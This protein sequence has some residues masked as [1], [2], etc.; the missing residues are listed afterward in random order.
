MATRTT[1]NGSSTGVPW[2]NTPERPEGFGDNQARHF[3][4]LYDAS[5]LPLTGV[6]GS[7]DTVTATV[8]P[9]IGSGGLVDGMKFTITWA[10]NNTGPT[11]LAIGTLPPVPVLNGLGGT[12]IADTLLAGSRTMLEYVSG[13]FRILTS[14]TGNS[15][16]TDFFQRITVSGVW[17]KPPGYS[18]DA[19][20]T[21][22]A[23]G[24]GGGGG[25]DSVVP[26]GNGGGGGGYVEGQI[27]YSDLPST[28]TVT[29]GAGGA[30]NSPGQNT[31]FG[32]IMTAYGGAPSGV[33][34][35]MLSSGA[36][37]GLMGGG[38]AG[39]PAL[40]PQGGGGG[41]ESGSGEPGGVDGGRSIYG[42]GGGG[43]REGIGM[44][45]GVGGVSMF[46]GNGGP[47]G[48]AGVAPGGGGGTGAPGA[49]GRVEIFL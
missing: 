27:R 23:W 48:F 12:L 45:E 36:D 1:Y 30:I 41:G 18:D 46:G 25:L 14:G 8:D 31:M 39:G 40:L 29:I 6:G 35:G 24:G 37:G 3:R 4:T 10:L 15:V 5:A 19:V 49:P 34:G 2:P 17:S 28:V 26:K 9:E 7:G 42:G 20:F 21:I 38:T 11:T 32:S 43:G 22:R 44:V 16:R 47:A 13:A 33:G